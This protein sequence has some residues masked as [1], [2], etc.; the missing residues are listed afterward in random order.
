MSSFHTAVK[1]NVSRTQRYD[2]IDELIRAGDTRNLAVLVQLDGLRGEFRRYALDGLAE[3]HATARLESLAADR[4][5][6]R[7]LRRKAE[8]LI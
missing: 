5:I 3:C 4:S 2:A 7:P 6:D 1:T 8:R